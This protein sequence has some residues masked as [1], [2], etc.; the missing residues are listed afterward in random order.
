MIKLY[1]NEYDIVKG[2]S[3][4]FDNLDFKLSKPQSKIIPHIISSIINAEN[5]TTLDLSKSFID[6]SLLSNQS[7]I[8]KKLWRF[9]NNPKF[10]GI[11]FFNSSIKYI[12]NNAKAL[13]HNKLVVVMDHMFMKNNFV[14]LMF[15]LKIGKQSIPIW[16]KCDKTKSNRHHEIDEL[17]KKCLFSENVIFNAIK[18]VIKLLSPLKA[19]ITFLADRWF[20]NLKLMNFI[21]ESGHFFCIRAKVNSNVKVLIFD[22]KEN[23]KIY[24]KLADFNTQ[25]HHSLYYKDIELGDFHF[26]C[27]LS[28]ARNKLADDPWFI[29]SN[30]EPNQA[31]REYSHRFGAIEMLFKSQKTNGFN[32]EK[33]KT[34][35]LHAYENLYSLVCFAG[36]WLTI[37]G[38]DYTK[39]YK[40]VKNR[41]NI[42][43]VKKTK[44]NKSVRTLSLFNLGLTIFKRCYNS[45][46]NYKIKC[47]MQLY[48]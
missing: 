24:K 36:L 43:Y 46:I 44:N 21:N 14:T 29:L 28:I 23:H 17:T 32:L 26:K 31:L 19:K 6:D 9:F 38:I 40:K 11:N 13:K 34:R 30:I 5:I 20:C 48:L 41:L 1:N 33:T 7:S 47:N 8:E 27:N 37:I 45:Y 22:K 25:K 3:T 2:L 15:S 42:R 4:F 18:D 12:I 39:N 16:F 10:D 35:N